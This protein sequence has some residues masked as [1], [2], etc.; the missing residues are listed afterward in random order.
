MLGR[1]AAV[2]GSLYDSNGTAEVEIRYVSVLWSREKNL[3]ARVVL[4]P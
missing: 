3:V 1:A 2:P 4:N